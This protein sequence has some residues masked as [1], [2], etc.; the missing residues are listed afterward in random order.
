MSRVFT[1]V[2]DM[3]R[4]SATIVPKL[5]IFEQR[6]RH[7]DIDQD[8]VQRRSRFAHK[9]HNLWRIIGDTAMTLKPKPNH[10]K[11]SILKSQDWKK[12]VK[13]CWMWRFCLL[14]SSIAMV[15][16][17]INSCHKIVRPIKNTVYYYRIVEKTIMDFAPWLRT[18][19]HVNAYV[20]VFDQK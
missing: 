10:L 16:C 1:D 4:A 2:L 18:N 5:L 20:W 17:I 6:Q 13:F 12:H 15:W 9:S 3:K 11:R 7:M 19:S 14:F 8:N